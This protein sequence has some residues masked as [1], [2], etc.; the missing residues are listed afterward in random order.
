M[1]HHHHKRF[2]SLQLKT[3]AKQSLLFH[4]CRVINLYTRRV[5]LGP[6]AINPISIELLLFLMHIESEHAK[7]LG[8]ER[9][10][11][12]ILWQHGSINMHG[13]RRLE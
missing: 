8:S 9:A 12:F 13:E 11:E 10:P 5:R 1:K 4:S 3:Y 7:V 6:A 2:T